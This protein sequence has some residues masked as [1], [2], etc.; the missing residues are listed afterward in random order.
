MAIDWGKIGANVVSSV[1]G[2]GVNIGTTA[3]TAAVAAKL[4]PKV[5]AEKRQQAA[6]QPAAQPQQALTAVPV[7]AVPAWQKFAPHVLGGV[8]V[9]GLTY[10]IV[11]ERRRRR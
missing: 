2:A 8:A 4:A 5:E 1:I 10:L 6:Q 11:R 9:L 7:Q 3:L